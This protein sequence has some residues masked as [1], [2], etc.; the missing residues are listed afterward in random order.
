MTEK[1]PTQGPPSSYQPGK[2][3]LWPFLGWAFL[4]FGL[5]FLRLSCEEGYYEKGGVRVQ[6]IVLQKT[7]SPGTSST[8]GSPS[9]PSKHY[10]S[11]RFTTKEGRTLEGRYE[12][13]PQMWGKLKEGDPVIV[14]YL[15]DSP[16]TNRIPEQRARSGTWR[17]M[18][19]VLLVASVILFIIGRRQRRARSK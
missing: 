13:L 15:P 18:A 14:E 16:D 1:Q 10:V 12:L 17:I 7:Y 4:I 8:G 3:S 2:R 19:L 5:V 6:G 9:S 11:Y